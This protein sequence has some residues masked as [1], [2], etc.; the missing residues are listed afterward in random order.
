MSGVKTE[1]NLRSLYEWLD[2]QVYQGNSRP[3]NLSATIILS[4]YLIAPIVGAILI[5]KS[6]TNIHVSPELFWVPLGIATALSAV[7]MGWYYL[8][9][10]TLQKEHARLLKGSRG[11]VWKLYSAR[12]SGTIEDII[13]EGPAKVLNDAAFDFLRCH[14]ALQSPA[15]QSLGKESSWS[16]AR[17][18]AELAMEGAMARLMV[19]IGQGAAPDRQEVVTLLRDIHQTTEEIIGVVSRLDARNEFPGA[20]SDELRQVL[21][22]LRMLNAAHDEI[23]ETRV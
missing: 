23:M 9:T 2:T 4:S 17:T 13:G 21:G 7:T 20:G 11:F 6:H 19:A 1:P 14:K 5:K 10:R 15:W 16:A 3:A 18:K 8:R 22:E 12:W